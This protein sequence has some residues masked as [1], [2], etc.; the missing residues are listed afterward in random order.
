MAYLESF[1]ENKKY[2]Y[3]DG[4]GKIVVSPIYDSASHSY[5]LDSKNQCPYACVKLKDKWGIIMRPK[6]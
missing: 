5:G 4:N 1:E 2:G 3:K 6:V